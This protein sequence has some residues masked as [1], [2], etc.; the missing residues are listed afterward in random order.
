MF[1]LICAWINGW[2]NNRKAGDLRRHR[3]HYDVIVMER[4]HVI[5]WSHTTVVPKDESYSNPSSFKQL[6][7]HYFYLQTYSGL[8]LTNHTVSDS[9]RE[10]DLLSQW[11]TAPLC[12]RRRRPI[13]GRWINGLMKGIAFICITGWCWYHS[14]QW[15][16]WYSNAKW[17]FI[18]FEEPSWSCYSSAF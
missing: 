5:R 11:C 13:D 12:I 1:S 15:I 16:K 6:T 18:F 7:R 14:H 2:V 17:C 3:A 4:A 9:G 10:S 8:D